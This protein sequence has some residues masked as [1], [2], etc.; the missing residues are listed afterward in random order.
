MV[1]NEISLRDKAAVAERRF[2]LSSK[3]RN[4]TETNFYLDPKIA[5]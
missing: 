4:K 1:A 3:C 5:E 2:F